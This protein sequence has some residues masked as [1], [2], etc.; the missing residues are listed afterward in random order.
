M[1]GTES[2]IAN[3]QSFLELVVEPDSVFELRVLDTPNRGTFSGYFTDPAQAAKAAAHWD[4]KANIYITLNP[5]HP[6]CLARSS[7]RVTPHPKNTTSDADILR[8]RW[9]LVDIDPVRPAGVPA[10]D[11]EKQAAL[12]LVEAIRQF[13]AENGWP[14][15]V[16]LDTGNGAALLYRID[17]PND[18]PSRELVKRCL[19][20]LA[21]MFDTEAAHVDLSTFNAARLCRVV[22]TVNRKGDG[23][24]DRPH[25]RSQIVSAPA[26]LAIV[27]TE[28]L[29][30]LAARVPENSAPAEHNGAKITLEEI[31]KRLESKGITVKRSSWNGGTR[32]VL[33]P[34]PFNPDHCNGSA[35]VVQL[36]SGALAAGCHHNSCQSY[37]WEDLRQIL[38][39][40]SPAR[41]PPPPSTSKAR[42]RA[43]SPNDEPE[44]TYSETL[45]RLAR[46][47]ELWHNDQEAWATIW[48]GDHKEHWRVQSSQFRTWLCRQFY[49]ERGK[50]PCSTTVREVLDTIE[51]LARYDSPAYP[52]YTRVAWTEDA[53]YLDLCNEKWQAVR[54]DATG[55][56]VVDN[57][58]VRFYR[59]RGMDPLPI[60]DSGGSIEDLRRFIR[61]K[62]GDWLSL[63]AWL[64]GTFLPTGTFPILIVYGPQG[65]GKSTTV[66]LLRS[67]IDP[68]L[69]PERSQPAD[70]RDLSIACRNSYVVCFGNLSG[71]PSWFSDALCRVASGAG[72]STRRLYS[73]FEEALFAHRRPIIL[74]GIAQPA[75]RPDLLDRAVVV[76]LEPI[77]DAERLPEAVLLQQFAEVYPKLLGA[78]LDAVSLALANRGRVTATALPRLADFAIWTAGG[79]PAL[80]VPAEKVLAHLFDVRDQNYI[81][82]ATAD[83]LGE[84]LLKYL[85]QRGGEWSGTASELLQ[86]LHQFAEDS[87]RR[88]SL[89]H[90]AWEMGRA[91]R[92]LAP[93]FR[94][95]G[96]EVKFERQGHKWARVVSLKK[97]GIK[98]SATS[99]TSALVTNLE[100]TSTYSKT[101]CRRFADVSPGDADVFPGDADVFPSQPASGGL[102]VNPCLTES[103]DNY[104]LDADIADVADVFSPTSSHQQHGP[105]K[106][107]EHQPPDNMTVDQNVGNDWQYDSETN[108]WRATV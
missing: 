41:K 108:M 32:L 53:I 9:L 56:Q 39:P 4:G 83:P 103:Y 12:G 7:G 66:R 19:Q 44:E 60:P 43:T 76:E 69:S 34:C 58:P 67:L 14:E 37:E 21:V 61:V 64:L 42:R 15:P 13:T 22:G 8:R 16:V 40:E 11:S 88:V 28:K 51:G 107:E 104:Q 54:I 89:P 79:M 17:L 73:D 78:L 1:S 98:T 29:Q 80:G 95:I 55:W 100:N 30:E 31:A 47:A 96:V 18:D 86:E 85:E 52:V 38:F 46:E 20:A 81:E 50:S 26:E 35:Y 6:G 65:A 87:Q 57:P 82:A 36:K 59:A 101:P 74:N 99:A 33:F 84:I 77:T 62:D 102:S 24:P 94:P 72:Y 45:M 70:E 3:C 97:V 92:R 71:I 2:V 63:L 48:V 105:A 49:Q 91:L 93:A 25:R 5:V 27:P 23:T 90:N 106:A 10:T 75:T 68:N